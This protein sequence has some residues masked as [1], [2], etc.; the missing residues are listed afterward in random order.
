MTK[1]LVL[2]AL[3][4]TAITLFFA[5]DLGRYVS[6]PY[7]QEQRGALIELRDA[8][9]WLATLG[10]FTIYVLATALSLPG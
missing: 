1:R 3:I 9:P 7:L 10:F 5:F 8:N 4:A 2:L 6:L